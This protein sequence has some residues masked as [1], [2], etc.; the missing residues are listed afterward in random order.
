MHILCLCSRQSNCRCTVTSPSNWW[1]NQIMWRHNLLEI[2]LLSKSPA[3]IVRIY[4]TTL[5]LLVEALSCTKPTSAIP[6][7]YRR[8]HFTTCQCSLPWLVMY[9]LTTLIA[10]EI[11]ER[12]SC[13]FILKSFILV[14]ISLY[15]LCTLSI[16]GMV[17]KPI[18]CQ[19]GAATSRL[20]EVILRYLAL[21]MIWFWALVSSKIMK[22]ISFN[23]LANV[24]VCFGSTW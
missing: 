18:S 20:G 22:R 17:L 11:F 13:S 12:V 3:Y 15:C 1:H 7:I 24:Y 21:N 10:C 5:L 14:C 6:L 23:T 4:K 16:L 9:L 2:S 19:K 8:I